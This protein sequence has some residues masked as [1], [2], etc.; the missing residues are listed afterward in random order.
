MTHPTTWINSELAHVQT[1]INENEQKT[2]Y[3]FFSHSSQ[4]ENINIS[5]SGQPI[6]KTSNHKFRGIFIDDKMKF[7]KHINKLCSKLSQSTVIIR[8]ILHM[9]PLNVLRSLYYKLIYSRLTYAV[10]ALGSAFNSITCR[11]ESLISREK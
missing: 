7:D 1:W 2:N 4:I 8:R 5:L 11:M 9:V 3:M 6:A 10:T